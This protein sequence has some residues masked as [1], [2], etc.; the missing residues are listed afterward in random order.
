MPNAISTATMTTMMIKLHVI[1]LK[2]EMP[3]VYGQIFDTDATTHAA[4][5]KTK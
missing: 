3:N 4:L 2:L 1:Q 5:V